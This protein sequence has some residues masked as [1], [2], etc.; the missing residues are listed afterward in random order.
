MKNVDGT[1]TVCFSGKGQVVIPR[2]L[3]KEF[4]I[5]D[6]T[7]AL[8]YQEGDHIALRPMTASRYEALQ[9]CLKGT[10]CMK[11]FM[12]ERKREREC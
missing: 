8:V 10:G 4:G 6:G 3:R 12:E 5:E 11:M 2:R 7:R 9:G 1:D